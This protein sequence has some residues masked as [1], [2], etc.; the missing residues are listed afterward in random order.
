MTELR[1]TLEPERLRSLLSTILMVKGGKG[2][3]SNIVGEVKPNGVVFK[4]ASLNVI[5]VQAMYHSKYFLEYKAGEGELPLTKTLLEQLGKGFN[6][7]EKVE[8]FIDEKESRIWV[9]GKTETYNEPLTE[10]KLGDLPF[11]MANREGIGT[12]PEKLT[13]DNKSAPLSFQALFDTEALALPDAEKYVFTANGK[14]LKVQIEGIG[15]YTKT[16]PIKKEKLN[17]DLTIAIDGSYYQTLVSNL[18]GE[19]WLSAS[20]A[21]IVFTQKAKDFS[22]SYVLTSLAQVT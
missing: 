5:A 17:K 8:F 18:K 1:I 12:L 10:G 7:D 9:K 22:L 14:E 2:L 16:I 19:V 6:K 21:G 3:I 20:E 11:T 15:V 13:E 4:D